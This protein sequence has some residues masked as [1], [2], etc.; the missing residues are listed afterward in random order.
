MERIFRARYCFHRG[1]YIIR[2]H[3]L[4]VVGHDGE[5][6]NELQVIR[7]ANVPIIGICLG[8]ELIA[9]AF[10]SPLYRLETKEKGFVKLNIVQSHP[11]FSDIAQVKVFE[12]HRWVVKSVR[13]PL[14]GLA[15]SKD[16]YE[17]IIHESRPIFGFQFHP[18]MFQDVTEGDE[19]MENCL[20]YIEN[21][22][23]TSSFLEV[24]KR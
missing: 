6:Q 4:S 5:Y 13:T 12:S 17:V 18:E 2:R 7:E 19:I 23:L 1:D 21:K 20:Q 14:V 8:F 9:H 22:F 16:G 15:R 24:Y 10:G 3:S 11:I